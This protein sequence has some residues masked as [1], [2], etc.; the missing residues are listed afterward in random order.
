[1]QVICVSFG[2]ASPWATS[3]G[4]GWA[5][6]LFLDNRLRGSWSWS[7]RFGCLRSGWRWNRLAIAANIGL[8]DLLT[9]ILN[10]FCFFI[11]HL[12]FASTL[13]FLRFRSLLFGWCRRPSSLFGELNCRLLLFFRI[14]NTRFLL[15]RSRYSLSFIYFILD[16]RGSLLFTLALDKEI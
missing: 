11:L 5:H 8:G 16:N 13:G 14:L 6:S 9:T 10:W 15:R 12:F 7:F 3:R 1:M 4:F 2:R